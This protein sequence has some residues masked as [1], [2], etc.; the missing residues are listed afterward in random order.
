MSRSIIARRSRTG[1]SSTTANMRRCANSPPRS[2]SGSP[3]CRTSP[4]KAELVAEARGAA[5]GD[6]AQGRAAPRSRG[7][8]AAL[9]GRADRRLS[10]AARARRQR[11]ISAR[12]ARA[13]RRELRQLPRRRPATRRR[14]WPRRMD[15]PPIAFTD[16]ARARERSLFALYQ[17]IDQG[18][19]GTAMASFAIC[20]TRT[21]GRSPSTPAAS[22]IPPR[23]PSR[24][25]GS[26]SATP[27]LR[28]PH[29]RSRSAGRPE[30]AA[31][32]ARDRRR[33]RRA[34]VIAYLRANP[35]PL[36]ARRAARIARPRP[37]APR[38]RASPPIEPATASG[39]S[40]LA[41][42]AYLDGFEPVEA[43]LAARDAGADG[44]GRAGDGRASR[45]DRRRRA[46]RRG[47]A[48]G[49]RR[50]T[51]CSTRPRRAL[52]PEA[53]S[54][55][56]TFLGAFTI[57]LRE[58]LEAL[59]IVVAMLAFLRKADRPRDGAPGPWRLDRRAR[60]RRRDL[61]GGD[62][63]HLDQRRQPRADRRLRLAARRGRS[64]CS[65]AS[66]CTARRRPTNGSAT[67]ARRS[68][69]RCPQESAWFL[70]LL[71]FI[72]VYREVFETILFFAA[73]SARGQRRRAARR[74]RGRRRPCWR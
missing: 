14:R 22:P 44:A 32:A 48:S 25:G 35:A 24:A 33:T 8:R 46:G 20:P 37:R 45:R 18:L 49:S 67:S 53:G 73:L 9:A 50:S 72:A 40:E 42:S 41:L 55:A 1:G 4:A 5:G 52:A 31:L 34:A 36:T 19:E 16:R 66:G 2:R 30:P 68:A 61:V 23:W 29:A 15:P 57:L 10:G 63:S 54:A 38:A 6:R 60:R 13:L 26:G 59:L 27:A 39:A 65:S 70:F 21:D 62:P 71:A 69:R 64:C 3:R 7:R 12:G 28:A 11:P 56:S 51:P 17:V 43:M 74:R 58:G 47:R